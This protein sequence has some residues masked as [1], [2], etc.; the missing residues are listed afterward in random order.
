[1]TQE[2]TALQRNQSI[3][4]PLEEITQR[5]DKQLPAFDELPTQNKSAVSFPR[6]IPNIARTVLHAGI[7]AMALKLH[8]E[9]GVLHRFT[10]VKA[11][12][13]AHM[14]EA[15]LG[16]DLGRR[17]IKDAAGP[18]DFRQLQKVERHAKNANY[19]EFEQERGGTYRARRLRRFDHLIRQTRTALGKDCAAVDR[20]LQWM[21][22]MNVKQA[23]I[24]ATVFAAWNNLLLDGKQ[25]IDEEIVVEARENW[26]PNKKR[27]DR[28]KF[29]AAVKWLRQQDMAPQGKGRP[30]RHKREN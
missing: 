11:E 9:N 27:I 8:A 22:R 21:L 6:T 30:V 10:H 18:S 13:I 28:Q 16:I 23:E 12:K 1:M 24:V 4:K 26:H 3:E 14:V 29:F 19:F 17:P 7:L 20:L 25:P 15:L 5:S 2:V